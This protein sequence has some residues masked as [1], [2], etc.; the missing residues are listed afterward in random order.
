M[1]DD[2]LTF[3]AAPSLE[4]LQQMVDNRGDWYMQQFQFT[5]S[6]NAPAPTRVSVHMTIE[7][8]G[9]EYEFLADK[10]T[11]REALVELARM[12]V[13]ATSSGSLVWTPSEAYG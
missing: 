2:E 7:C 1:D 10:P 4:N 11:L 3:M 8:E 6:L 9:E 13:G 5:T 12:F